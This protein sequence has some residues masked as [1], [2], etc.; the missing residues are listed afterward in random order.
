MFWA[1]VVRCIKKEGGINRK[2]EEEWK[3]NTAFCGWYRFGSA[4]NN[5]RR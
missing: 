3:N 2:Y 4:E 1:I 5:K